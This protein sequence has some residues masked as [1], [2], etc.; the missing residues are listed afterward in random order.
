MSHPKSLSGS[1]YR[2]Y[3]A[4]STKSKTSTLNLSSPTVCFSFPL[5]T[6]TFV[7]ESLNW[8]PYYKIFVDMTK[9]WL[10][11]LPIMKLNEELMMSTSIS[12]RLVHKLSRIIRFCSCQDSLPVWSGDCRAK[13]RH[14]YSGSASAPGTHTSTHSSWCEQSCKSKV[15]CFIYVNCL[16]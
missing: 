12:K 7:L 16:N 10:S 9:T 1:S 6:L 8:N 13:V 14:L 15:F 2:T 3:S 11:F 4:V 5:Q